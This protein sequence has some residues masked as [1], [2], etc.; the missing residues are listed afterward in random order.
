[1][2]PES[3]PRPQLVTPK[4]A[5]LALSISPRKLWSLTESGDV[6]CVRIGRSVRYDTADLAEFIE[7]SRSDLGSKSA[8]GNSWLRP[9]HDKGGQQ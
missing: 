2:S 7:A 6:R 3:L 1:M 5:A 4:T 8:S 9:K